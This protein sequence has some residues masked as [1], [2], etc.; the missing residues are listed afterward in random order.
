[1]DKQFF[2]FFAMGYIGEAEIEVMEVRIEKL[3]VR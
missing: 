2:F 1:M 3:M